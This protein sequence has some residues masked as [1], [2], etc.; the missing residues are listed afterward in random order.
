MIK[1]T[2]SRNTVASY[3]EKVGDPYDTRLRIMTLFIFGVMLIILARLFFIMILQHDFYIAL[4]AGSHT[5]YSQL[6]PERGNIYIQDS[7]TGEE[8]PI[9]LNKDV[10]TVF[11]DTR[12]IKTQEEA[13]NVAEELALALSYSDE[14]KLDLFN[15][16][17][18]KD[19]PYEPIKKQ[20]EESIVDLLKQ[21]KLLGVGFVRQS[22]RFYPEG[23]LAAQTIGFVGKDSDGSDIGR[24]GVEG[25]WH[26]ELAGSGGFLKASRGL[27]GGI[28]PLA[29]KSFEPAQDGSDILLTLDRTLQYTACERLRNAMKLYQAESA[30]LIIL[31]PKTGAI[32][33]M[34][35]LPDFNL[36]EYNKVEDTRVYNNSTIFIPY[37]PGSVFK[38]LAMAAAI[39]EEKVSPDT[40]FYDSGSVD[41]NCSKPIKN[42]GGRIYKEQTMKGVLENSINTGMVFVVN[43]IGKIIFIDYLK[44]F[45]LGLKTGIR[46][47]SEISGTINT[48]Y[49]KT[50]DKIDC[51][52]ATASFGQ[53]ITVTPLQMISSFGAIANNGKMMRP[54]VIEEIRQKDGKVIRTLP[55]IISEVMTSRTASLLSAM[56]V[57]VVDIGHAKHAGV[58]GYYVAGK[59]GTAQIAGP[60]GYIDQTNHTFIGFA[61]V[62]DPAFVMLV[63]FEKPKVNFSA[64]T[65]APVFGDIAEFIL[66]YYQIVPVRQ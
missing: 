1:K 59:T 50:G 7:R 12:D 30:S 63:K 46:L 19:D 6:F 15:R 9:A 54:Y 2:R 3:K 32:R 18:G 58:H 17:N 65:S 11:V 39:N 21:K 42:A 13:Q 56:L 62:D 48:L 24:Y 44:R 37:E 38:P 23:S 29:G 53:G 5:L 57:L 34:C 4:A 14:Q 40:Y 51:Y 27:V 31:D 61:P 60:N 64:N 33:A 35:S 25:Y 45:G 16:I 22:T 52:T 41:A 8:F 55:E 10:F 49:E 20:V 47:D 43:K 28:I 66:D 36:N 26:K